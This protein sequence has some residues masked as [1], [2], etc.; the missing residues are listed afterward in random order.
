MQ[1]AVRLVV[2]LSMAATSTPAFADGDANT[3]DKNVHKPTRTEPTGEDAWE[4][5]GS[6]RG[7]P[8]R[9]DPGKTK[10]TANEP[11]GED[12]WEDI[13]T[14][15]GERGTKAEANPKRP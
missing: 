4:D 15:R 7:E 2:I 13:G 6:G 11:T 5:I 1:N 9:A 10:P 14:G 8:M 12:A 3:A